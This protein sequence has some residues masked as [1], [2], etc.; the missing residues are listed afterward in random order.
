MPSEVTTSDP[1]ITVLP[2]G[3]ISVSLDVQ[4][5]DEELPPPVVVNHTTFV[6]VPIP[7]PIPIPIPIPSASSDDEG[8]EEDL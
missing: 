2:D 8:V 3:S 6:P 7:V 4:L 5:P 1:T